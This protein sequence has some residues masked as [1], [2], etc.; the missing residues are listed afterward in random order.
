[1]TFESKG[2]KAALIS[3]LVDFNLKEESLKLI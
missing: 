2:I 3:K 1:M